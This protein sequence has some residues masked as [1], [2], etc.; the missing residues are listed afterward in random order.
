VKGVECLGFGVIDAGQNADDKVRG[1]GVVVDIGSEG[2]DKRILVCKTDEQREM[3]R[4][5]ALEEKF[6]E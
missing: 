5:C 1:G 6:W 4:E 3:A 2:K